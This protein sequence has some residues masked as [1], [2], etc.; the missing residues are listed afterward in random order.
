MPTAACHPGCRF[1]NRRTSSEDGLSWSRITWALVAIASSTARTS[2]PAQFRL[3]ILRRGACEEATT[4]RRSP[5]GVGLNQHQEIIQ[6]QAASHRPGP[7]LANRRSGAPRSNGTSAGR[8]RAAAQEHDGERYARARSASQTNG[9]AM[10]S[11]PRIR[12]G[13]RPV[14]DLFGKRGVEASESCPWPISTSLVQRAQDVAPNGSR[15]S[16]HADRA[17]HEPSDPPD[18]WGWCA[19]GTWDSPAR[20]TLDQPAQSWGSTFPNGKAH[21]IASG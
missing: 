21:R 16:A 14:A 13:L 4:E 6:A 18:L 19:Q 11:G 10:A 9:T 15:R 7:R 12:Q 5:S 2:P 8:V 3:T 1:S 17:G 20:P